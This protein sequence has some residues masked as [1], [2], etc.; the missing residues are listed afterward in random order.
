MS[1]GPAADDVLAGWRRRFGSDGRLQRWRSP[2][3]E[4]CDGSGLS[5]RAGLHELMPVSRRIRQMIQ[6]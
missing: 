2:G 3:C 4:S 1:A 6:T 5:G